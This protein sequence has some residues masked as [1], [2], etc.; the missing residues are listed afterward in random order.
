MSLNTET[1]SA[2]A[3]SESLC[4]VATATTYHAERGNVAWAALTTTQQEQA[5][6]KATDYMER[7]YKSQWQGVR[8]YYAQAL[9][10]PRLG[11]MA[12]GYY[13][14]AN[15]VPIPIQRAC[16]ELALKA[17]NG[18]LL[19]D[20]GQQKLSSKVGDIEVTYDKYSSRQT[21]YAAVNAM[22]MP[23]FTQSSSIS[24]KLAR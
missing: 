7:V 1:G 17:S 22:L 8:S 12:N 14:L 15:I 10:W 23:Y 11:V 5:L 20:T 6:R 18:E 9:D 4:D 16:A 19:I 24:R 21:Q 3:T 2:S 13:V